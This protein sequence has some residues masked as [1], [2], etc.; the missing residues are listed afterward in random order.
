M[1]RQDAR[2]AESRFAWIVQLTKAITSV[3]FA[4]PQFKTGTREIHGNCWPIPELGKQG[5]RMLREQC[6]TRDGLATSGTPAGSRIARSRARGATAH[7]AR[8]LRRRCRTP[9]PA[10]RVRTRIGSCSPTDTGRQARNRPR[11]D[12]S[13]DSCGDTIPNLTPKIKYGVPELRAIND[14]Q[15]RVRCGKAASCEGRS[16]GLSCMNGNSAPR[17]A[18]LNP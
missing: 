8:G 7:S 4:C 17:N 3:P 12:R 16:R 1:L 11:P 10:C 13:R 2:S 15:P 14:P 18:V 6:V 5:F 9:R